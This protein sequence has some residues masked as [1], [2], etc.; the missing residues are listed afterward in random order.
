M[1]YAD[2]PERKVVIELLEYLIDQKVLKIESIEGM[3]SHFHT[4]EGIIKSYHH[5]KEMEYY[6]WVK[7]LSNGIHKNHITKFPDNKEI[8]N[9]RDEF[10]R[11][12]INTIGE[13]R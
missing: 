7:Y 2:S 13:L 8:E 6:A 9:C 10:C 5:I 12:A 11:S 4:L 3:D 1:V